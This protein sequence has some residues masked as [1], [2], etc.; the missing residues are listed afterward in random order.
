MLEEPAYNDIFLSN[1]ATINLRDELLRVDGVSDVIIF[2]K[3]DYSI[4]VWLDP[5]KMAYRG[6]NAGDVANAISL[7]NLDVPAGRLGQPPAAAGQPFDVPIEALGRLKTPEQ[8]ADIIVK[9]DQGRTASQGAAATNVRCQFRRPPGS[10]YANPLVSSTASGG[11][12]LPTALGVLR[13]TSV[14]SAA[15]A[16]T[17]AGPTAGC[18]GG[19]TRRAAPAP[20]AA[21]APAGEGA[22]A[23]GRPRRRWPPSPDRRP[24]PAAR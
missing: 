17:T 3:R 2:G 1:Y 7:Q 4:R 16:T 21:E 8:F 19:S 15:N 11:L 5:Q 24:R 18:S 22:P 20:A 10:R 6:I 23:A 13:A 12:T 9:V 14:Q